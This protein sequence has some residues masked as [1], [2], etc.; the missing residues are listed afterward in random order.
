MTEIFP[1]LMS[2]TKPQFEEA[3]SRVYIKYTMP[4]HIVFKLQ[5]AKICFKVLKELQEK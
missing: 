5:H 3:Q 1:K 2:Y 4:D